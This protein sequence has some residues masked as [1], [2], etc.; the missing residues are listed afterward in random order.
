MCDSVN[1]VCHVIK[2]YK[3]TMFV[4]FAG[5]RWKDIQLP[6]LVTKQL[7]QKCLSSFHVFLINWW[8]L[9]SRSIKWKLVTCHIKE[10]KKDENCFDDMLHVLMLLYTCMP[11]FFMLRQ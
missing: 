8:N 4:N 1:I 5:H 3:Y 2:K 7:N 10:T 6:C 11:F 9:K